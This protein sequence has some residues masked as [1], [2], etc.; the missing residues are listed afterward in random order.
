MVGCLDSG[1]VKGKIVLCD[2]IGGYSVVQDAGGLGSLLKAKSS[3]ASSNL[4]P[5]PVSA[6]VDVDY[7]TVKEYIKTTE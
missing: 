1:L 3:E 7:D 2:E 6:L 4:F 5:V